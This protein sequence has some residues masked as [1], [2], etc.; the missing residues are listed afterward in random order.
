MRKANILVQ[1][2]SVAHSYTFSKKNRLK[3]IILSRF[4]KKIFI[5]SRVVSLM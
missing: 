3:N 5:V 4:Y 2:A 1:L